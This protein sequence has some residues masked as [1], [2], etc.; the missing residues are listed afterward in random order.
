MM[1]R[2]HPRRHHRAAAFS[3]VEMMVAVAVSS[4]IVFALYAVFNQTQKA[5]RAG[6]QQVDV[7]EGGR[8]AMDMIVADI[9]QMV[10]FNIPDVTNYYAMFPPTVRVVGIT[11]D[12][13]QKTVTNVLREVFFANQQ[14]HEYEFIGYRFAPDPLNEPVAKL[15]RFTSR[16]RTTEIL[17]QDN[18][19][20]N[21][22]DEFA[23]TPSEDILNPQTRLPYPK[24]KNFD[25]I[26]DNVVHFRLIPYTRDGYR[27]TRELAE[28]DP[29]RDK[30]NPQDGVVFLQDFSQPDYPPGTFATYVFKYQSLPAFVDIELGVLDPKVA[31]TLRGMPSELAED[32]LNRQ[33]DSIHLF[34]KRVAILPVF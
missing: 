33:V 21:G 32:Y 34:R 1:D 19:R 30:Y 12:T 5:F 11:E 17:S 14:N 20:T 26:L 15:L 25:A 29:Y 16:V 22:F 31:E 18:V 8:A 9:E 10:A 6:A 7:L 28:E 2:Q 3:L 24:Y 27:W 4:V 23:L 13:A